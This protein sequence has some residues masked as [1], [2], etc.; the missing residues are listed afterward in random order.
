MGVYGVLNPA[1]LSICILAL[2]S[3]SSSRTEVR[4][5]KKGSLQEISFKTSCSSSLVRGMGEGEQ[6]EHMVHTVCAC[7]YT[8][9][10]G[11]VAELGVCTNMTINGSHE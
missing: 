1:D 8:Y 4:P 6:K 10:N 7:A 5:C 2:A 9:T 11:L 3:I